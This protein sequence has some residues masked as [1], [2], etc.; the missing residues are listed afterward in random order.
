MREQLIT[1]LNL[2]NNVLNSQVDDNEYRR[3]LE[4]KDIVTKLHDKII[5][6]LL[7]KKEGKRLSNDN[8]VT[9]E[10]ILNLKNV[11]ILELFPNLSSDIVNKID[12][13]LKLSGMIFFDLNKVD[14][15]NKLKDILDEIEVQIVEKIAKFN[16]L[17]DEKEQIQKIINGLENDYENIFNDYINQIIE[18]L[19]NNG[20]SEIEILSILKELAID[21]ELNILQNKEI[22]QQK[23]EKYESDSDEEVL[24]ENQEDLDTI[25]RRIITLLNDNGYSDIVSY[26]ENEQTKKIEDKKNELFTYGNLENIAEIIKTFRNYNINLLEEINN[27]NLFKIITLLLHSSSL[28]IEIIFNLALESDICFCKYDV[29][30]N[31]ILDENGRPQI[32][33][34]FLLEHP[35]RFISRKKRYKKR[36][37]EPI[38]IDIDSDKIGNMNDFL[39]N[40]IFFKNLGVDIK[41]LFRKFNS[42]NEKDKDK[43]SV[44]R[45]FDEPHEKILR[46][47]N[48]F[49]FYQIPKESY[50]ESLSCFIKSNPADTIDMC[51]ELNIFDYLKKNMSRMNLTIDSPL[52][53]RIVRTYQLASILPNPD[54][55]LEYQNA[56][57]FLFRDWKG[58]DSGNYISGK[59]DGYIAN[60]GKL[61]KGLKLDTQIVGN[62]GREITQ[63]YKRSDVLTEEQLY[64]FKRFDV[65]LKNRD[66]NSDSIEL[67]DQKSILIRF[68]NHMSNPQDELISVYEFGRNSNKI[69]ISKL[70]FYRIYNT[71]IKAGYNLENDHDCILYALTYNSILTV[72][73]FNLIK[74]YVDNLFKK[75]PQKGGRVGLKK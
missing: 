62:N 65:L 5:T 67:I 24:I 35:S 51:I 7:I 40:I 18:F 33:I 42:Q 31:L 53:Y 55:L 68:L 70:K 45:Y 9:K 4:L 2:R 20:S 64:N 69:R 73:Q 41:E 47:K 11:K 43:Q 16:I 6:V 23:I 75:I 72:E 25:K 36:G 63:C 44:G 30:G 52:F 49:D 58:D 46:N 57:R 34:N 71:L 61:K 19:K 29:F 1:Q 15:L 21:I 59:L 17:I 26:F 3:V 27:G 48:I 10:D 13:Y 32:N 8:K 54:N 38:P 60:P 50:L 28:N 22:K 14:I 37:N 39:K 56:K 12:H 66:T 74:N